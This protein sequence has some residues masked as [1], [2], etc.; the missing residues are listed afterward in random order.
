MYNYHANT[1]AKLISGYAI[2]IVLLFI[3]VSYIYTEMKRFMKPNETEKI[4]EERKK[5][6]NQVSFQLY[7]SEIIAQSILVNQTK[8]EKKYILAI[9]TALSS[10][11]NL[12]NQTTDTIQRLRFD[13]IISLLDKKKQCMK[14]LVMAI[15]KGDANGLYENQLDQWRHHNDSLLGENRIER[16]TMLMHSSHKAPKS[17][18]KVFSNV[19]PKFFRQRKIQ[20]L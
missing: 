6:I 7:K 15:N 10:I 19:L 11:H 17:R 9:D 1:R 18:R 4:L 5:Q 8:E 3:S 16:K 13:T 20:L 14:Q 2:L 12:Y